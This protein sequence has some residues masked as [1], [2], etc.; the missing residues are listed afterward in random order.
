MD[1][2]SVTR[3]LPKAVATLEQR[4]GNTSTIP[5]KRKHSP[6]SQSVQVIMPPPGI[7][8]ITTLEPI[9][10]SPVL[11]KPVSLDRLRSK[12]SRNTSDSETQIRHRRIASKVSRASK[13]SGK[14]ASRLGATS[15]LSPV[16]LQNNQSALRGRTSFV[17]LEN[18]AVT[19]VFD[20]EVIPRVDLISSV[21]DTDFTP[22][23]I[24]RRLGSFRAGEFADS[25]TG[26]SSH[27]DLFSFK[28]IGLASLGLIS[29]IGGPGT[30]LHETAHL[31]TARLFGNFPNGFKPKIHVIP[32]KRGYIDLNE[33]GMAGFNIL[34]SHL[35]PLSNSI[36]RIAGIAK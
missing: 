4:V 15:R 2:K 23:E 31:L 12:E 1:S 10:S 18:S 11:P 16:P 14:A 33:I 21:L 19:T 36:M 7:E 29:D 32:F 27:T 5:N 20:R 8:A 28:I 6:Q 26:D 9:V 17:S 13:I 24:F 30:A 3:I 25:Y 22:E 34:G 35:E